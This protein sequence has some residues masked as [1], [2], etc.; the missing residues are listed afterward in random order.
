MKLELEFVRKIKYGKVVWECEIEGKENVKLFEKI[1]DRIDTKYYDEAS[2]TTFFDMRI[3]L[4]VRKDS[5]DR[6]VIIVE[7]NTDSF[8]LYGS[9]R[10]V[11][12]EELDKVVEKLKEAK[13]ELEER[14]I[15]KYVI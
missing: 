15:K 13:E 5:E 1:L 9:E 14:V 12:E 2:E 3:N 7:K 4:N 6:L 8:A 10:D 11:S